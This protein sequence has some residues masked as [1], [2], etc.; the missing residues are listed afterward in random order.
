MT[1]TLLKCFFEEKC[2][3]EEIELNIYHNVFINTRNVRHTPYAMYHYYIIIYQRSYVTRT[4][5]EGVIL[6]IILI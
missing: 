4:Y 6:L 3:N 1:S 5:I 2:R